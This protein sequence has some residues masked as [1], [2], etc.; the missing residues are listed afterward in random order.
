M[1]EPKRQHL[2][3][4]CYLQHFALKHKK[5]WHID[6][7]E[8]R[9]EPQAIFNASI[10]NVC[11]AREFYTFRKL[12]DEHK[13]FLERFYSQTVEADYTDIYNVLSNPKAIKISDNMRFKIMSFI[14]CQHFRT[15]KLTNTFNEFWNRTLAHGHALIKPDAAE[16]KIYFGD[17][18]AGNS[19]IDF[20]NK[21]LEEVQKESDE[22][23]RE[24][25]NL[26]N[27]QW[28]RELTL[29]RI[30][31]GI[32]VYK[33]H[34][35]H[36]LITSDNPVVA[37]QH[38]FDP[39]I[40]IKLPIDTH[41]IAAI[42]PFTEQAWFDNNTINRDYLDEERSYF[43]STTNNMVQ[44]EQCQQFV[45]GHR[46]TIENTLKTFKDLDKQK[47]EQE[48]KAYVKKLN[49]KLAVLSAIKAQR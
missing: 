45:L 11:V 37:G 5:N 44:I 24:Q 9:K 48:G 10:D 7:C 27:Y 46:E 2:V 8:V 1:N 21:T 20:E 13:R 34:P 41:H 15:A 12:P 14:I 43:E 26:K 6:A 31:D 17:D 30:N 19:F 28:F 16:K 4:R 42:V 47:F 29:R 39:T 33:I 35:K 36:K 22:D 18:D 32:V 3:P 23:N 25:I 40:F 38:I 49:D